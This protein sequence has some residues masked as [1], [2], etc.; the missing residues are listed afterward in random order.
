MHAY[1]EMSDFGFDVRAPAKVFIFGAH[2][3]HLPAPPEMERTLV[4]RP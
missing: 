2:P 1:L 3:K 4:F